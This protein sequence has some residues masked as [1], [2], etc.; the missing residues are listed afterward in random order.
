MTRVPI[1]VIA[2]PTYSFAPLVRWSPTEISIDAESFSREFGGK[3]YVFFHLSTDIDQP[4]A[5]GR[6]LENKH[7]SVTVISSRVLR[8]FYSLYRPTHQEEPLFKTWQKGLPPRSL[9]PTTARQWR[10][11]VRVTQEH[12]VMRET[13]APKD[14]DVARMNQILESKGYKPTLHRGIAAFNVR[15]SAFRNR[16]L[17][18]AARHTQSHPRNASIDDYVPAMDL[19][20]KRGYFVVRV[21]A[22]VEK[23]VPLVHPSLW[24][25]GGDEVHSEM[26]DFY[27]ASKATLTVSSCSGWDNLPPA[28]GNSVAF[29]GMGEQFFW[30]SCEESGEGLPLLVCPRPIV[31]Q[32]DGSAVPLSVLAADAAGPANIWRDLISGNPVDYAIQHLSPADLADA[33][34]VYEKCV[35]DPT[36]LDRI[37]DSQRVALDEAWKR[38]EP[39]SF[40][41]PNPWPVLPPKFLTRHSEWLLH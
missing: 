10:Q 3:T 38:I 41:R 9:A 27:L 19:L 40:V 33:T 8:W 22:L 26:L 37:R 16:Q 36:Y 35:Q 34:N 7:D 17:P 11:R 2:L 1:R 15:D 23:Q 4:F 21:G 5:V 32:R 13:F 31:Y 29:I 25:Y 20:I 39:F 18:Y 12:S 6:I 30:G 28:F 24:D 14:S